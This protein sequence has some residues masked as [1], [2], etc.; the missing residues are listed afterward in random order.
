M[1]TAE[2][3][4]FNRLLESIKPLAPVG[5]SEEKV[6]LQEEPDSGTPLTLGN[7]F[8]HHDTHPIVLDFSLLKA[9]QLEWWL[10]EPETLWTEIQRHFKTQVSELAR[11][12][13]QTV[14]TIHVSNAPWEQWQVFEKVVQGLNNNIPSWTLMQAPSLEQLF[15]CI[16]IMEGLR[17]AEFNSEVK[18]YMAGAV[19]NEDV[20]YV[21]PPLDFI[22]SEVSQPYYRCK[23]CGNEDSALFGDGKCDTCTKRYAPEQGLSML[24][25]LELVQ[26]GRGTNVELLLTFD[27]DAVQAKWDQVKD[28]PITEAHL[29]ENSVDVQ[30]LKLMIARDYMSMRRKQLMKQLTSIKSWLGVA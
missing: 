22:Q 6:L 16:D 29:E 17:H 18:L 27:P 13:I 23:D 5:E 4:F 20:T 12:K 8:T 26:Q 7:I 9:F 28:L 1:A 24:P 2:Q 3:E 25:N 10:W 30:V 11:A 14:K 21:P 19:L 15:V